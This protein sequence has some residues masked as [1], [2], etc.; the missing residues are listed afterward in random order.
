M[1]RLPA[2]QVLAGFVTRPCLSLGGDRFIL[3]GTQSAGHAPDEF[4]PFGG[5]Q[6]AGKESVG[7]ARGGHA[8]P[9]EL[10]VRMQAFGALVQ[11]PLTPPETADAE[12]RIGSLQQAADRAGI[13]APRRVEAA[14]IAGLGERD[15]GEQRGELEML[16][17][18]R[19]GEREIPGAAGR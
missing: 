11:G 4:L 18:M 3:P 1:G 9:G 19:Q 7:R 13:L 12:K 6:F 8:P 10:H 16:H 17:L 5:E 2:G 15:H 14:P